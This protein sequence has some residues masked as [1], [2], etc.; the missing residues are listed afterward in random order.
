MFCFSIPLSP[1]SSE[2]FG[3]VVNAQISPVNCGATIW[4]DSSST[5]NPT[6]DENQSKPQ[7]QP[8]TQLQAKLQ[9]QTQNATQLKANN[10]PEDSSE[11]PHHSPEA[12]LKITT[13]YKR[14]MFYINITAMH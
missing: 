5:L 1:S 6:A 10:S 14:M 9:S 3:A 13:P 7:P 11:Q 12:T 8:R 4:E 2:K